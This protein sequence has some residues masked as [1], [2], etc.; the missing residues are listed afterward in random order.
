MDAPVSLSH[1]SQ[2]TKHFKR[3][4]IKWSDAG[5]KFGLDHDT[6]EAIQKTHRSDEECFIAM[7]K[8]MVKD[9]KQLTMR[10]VLKVLKLTPSSNHEIPQLQAFSNPVPMTSGLPE[11]PAQLC[12]TV[13]VELPRLFRTNTRSVRQLRVAVPAVAVPATHHVIE[14]P[15]YTDPPNDERQQLIVSIPTRTNIGHT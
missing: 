9:S 7:L 1:V 5:L 3:S 13:P 15:V 8:E 12:V 4:D 10:N 2:L 11:W 14:L 6:L